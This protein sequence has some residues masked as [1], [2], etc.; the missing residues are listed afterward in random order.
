MNESLFIQ[1]RTSLR[2][3]PFPWIKL[4]ILSLF[5]CL[6]PEIV[7]VGLDIGRLSM[8]QVHGWPD[9]I[10]RWQAEGDREVERS[11]A[12]EAGIY[13]LDLVGYSIAQIFE[14][15]HLLRS[16]SRGSSFTS[17]AALKS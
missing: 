2:F 10:W 16:T 13:P 1:L 14:C 6:V 7:S 17:V 15:H 11:N 9:R 12:L 8:S 4:Q 3:G 5:Q